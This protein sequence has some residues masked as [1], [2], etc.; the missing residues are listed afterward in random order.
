MGGLCNQTM[1]VFKNKT[2]ATESG[3]EASSHA[4]FGTWRQVRDTMWF[5]PANRDS[6]DVIKNIDSNVTIDS[7]FSVKILDKDGK[8]ITEKI[9]IVLKLK[10]KDIARLKWDSLSRSATCIKKDSAVISLRSLSYLLG[11]KLV[12][13]PQKANN[14]T[15]TL[16]LSGDLLISDHADWSGYVGPFALFK[17]KDKLVSVSPAMVQYSDGKLVPIE[18]LK[19]KP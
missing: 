10:N 3:C 4:M 2:F 5:Y 7:F 9:K 16:N 11:K 8:N 15:I 14:F 13:T 12:L 19:Q 6:L 1:L 18:F 17:K